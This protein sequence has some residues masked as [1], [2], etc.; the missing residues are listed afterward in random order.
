M[1][2][3]LASNSFVREVTSFE[4]HKVYGDGQPPLPPCRG[5]CIL[6]SRPTVCTCSWAQTCLQPA[7]FLQ[8]DDEEEVQATVFEDPV[9]LRSFDVA[10]ARMKTV[11]RHAQSHAQLDGHEG[12]GGSETKRRGSGSTDIV[13]FW[14]LAAERTFL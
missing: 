10:R 14:H 9:A 3:S 5:L 6:S 7:E 11:V 13:S 2:G 4:T 8:S 1:L 12:G